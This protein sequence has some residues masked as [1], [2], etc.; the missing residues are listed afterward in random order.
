MD[1]V[2][3]VPEANR[4]QDSE[5]V[6]LSECCPPTLIR[7]C[8]ARILHRAPSRSLWVPLRVDSIS[9]LPPNCLTRSRIPSKPTPALSP[10][11]IAALLS[12]GISWPLSRTSS[13]ISPGVRDSLTNAVELP[14]WRWI[15]VRHSCVIRK[16][17]NSWSRGSLS[18]S[19]GDSSICDDLAA[20][21]EALYVPLP[22]GIQAHFIQ[23]RGV[24]EIGHRANV[25]RNLLPQIEIFLRASPR[26]R[27]KIRFLL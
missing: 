6:K 9:R 5:C 21:S 17:H 11:T 14:E 18:Q 12:S 19:A 10:E 2:S 15:F 22:C 25:G 13:L 16:R 20:L 8:L 1:S 3:T 7:Q 4:R 26:D 23:Q 27:A 24:K